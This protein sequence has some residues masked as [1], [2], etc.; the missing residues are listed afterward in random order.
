[1]QVLA[2]VFCCLLVRLDHERMRFVYI[3]DASTSRCKYVGSMKYVMIIIVNRPR[4]DRCLEQS[5][6]VLIELRRVLQEHPQF[7]Y[8]WATP[9]I[10]V[11]AIDALGITVES[12]LQTLSPNKPRTLSIHT[13]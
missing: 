10:D 2:P 1:M 4:K 13:P 6:S 3:A 7:G 11:I 5:E 8:C 12:T 9:G